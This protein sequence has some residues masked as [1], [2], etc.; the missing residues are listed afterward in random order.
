M[1]N[2][3]S[4]FARHMGESH[5]LHILSQQDHITHCSSP[6]NKRLQV[7]AAHKFSQPWFFNNQFD[8]FSVMVS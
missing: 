7:S 8:P 4:P 3:G 6:Q 2:N 1:L 5:F